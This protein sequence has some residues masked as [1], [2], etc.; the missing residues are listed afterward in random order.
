M[1]IRQLEREADARFSQRHRELLSRFSQEANR[2]LENQ[3]AGGDECKGR[4]QDVHLWNVP[5]DVLT[6]A[7]PLGYH[8]VR[9]QE[10]KCLGCPDTFEGREKHKSH[11]HDR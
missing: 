7:L 2:A 6:M 8:F 9:D 5:T 1:Q 3:R 10:R 4:H 11:A